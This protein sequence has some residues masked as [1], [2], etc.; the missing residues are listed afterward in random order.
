[1]MKR[2]S[3]YLFLLLTGSLVFLYSCKDDEDPK[4]APTVTAPSTITSANNG[5]AGTVTFSVSVAEGLT[6]TYTATGVNVTVGSASGTV[7]GTSLAIPFTAGTTAGA[8]SVSVTVKDSENQ[9]ASATATINVLPPNDGAITFN[10]NGKIPSTA[11]LVI[12][13]ILT[14]EGVDVASED[15]VKQVTVTVN[16]TAAPALGQTYTGN[17]A[18]AEYGF[19]VNTADLGAGTFSIVFTA[20]DANGSTSSFAHALTVT[21]VTEITLESDEDG[22]ANIEGFDEATQTLKLTANITYVLDGFVFVADGQTLEIEAGTVIKGLPGQGGGA[23]A[24]IISRGAK[25]MAEGT[26]TN[27][28]IMTGVA[29]NLMGSVPDDT[30]ALWGGLILLGKAPTNNASN[31]FEKAIEGLPTE[32]L[33]GDSFYGGDDAE[34]NSGVVKYVSIRHGGSLIGGDNEINGLTMGA[35][36]NGTTIEYV[37]VWSN[38]DD[39]FEWFGG[40]VNAKYL[41]SSWAGDDGYDYDEGFQGKVQFGLVWANKDNAKDDSWGGEHDG[42]VG[43]NESLAP[44]S[45]PELYNITYIGDDGL[46]GTI[47]FRDNAGGEYHNSIFTNFEN[48]I[49]LELRKDIASSYDRLVAGDLK[50]QNNVWFDIS[51]DT[52]AN[53]FTIITAGTVADAD[54]TAAQTFF[55]GYFTSAGNLVANPELTGVVPA[56]NTAV[57]TGLSTVPDD[58]FFEEVSYKG[59]FAP[60]AEPWIAGW[61][62]TWEVLGN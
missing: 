23:S 28:I 25:I 1:M 35:V 6:A 58:G 42:G 49:R 40:T 26:S 53:I 7:S 11:V 21:P 8:A 52:P 51:D 13:E 20:E 33:L 10:T 18:T 37:E 4:P 14:I 15:G 43:S 48:G 39:N 50:L 17:P 31:N 34:D 29:D 45:T 62:K 59:G 57:T 27:P 36:G 19:T 60:G 54:K 38:L 41:A 46:L 16:G 44:F 30:E 5:A 55:T 56:A 9:S 22:I 32:G 3:N 61:T 47:L 24:L 12:G 2:L